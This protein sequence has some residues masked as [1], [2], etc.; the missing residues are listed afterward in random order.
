MYQS[1]D[2]GEEEPLYRQYEPT[3]FDLVIVDEC[4]RGSAKESSQWR[5]I[6]EYFAPATQIGM[7][8][9]PISREDADT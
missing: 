6:L 1:L 2:S 9:T 7:T 8:A 4:H 3:Y 5:A